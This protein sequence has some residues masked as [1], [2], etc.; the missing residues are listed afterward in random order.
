M[1]DR[2]ENMHCDHLIVPRWWANADSGA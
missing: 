1:H 2:H